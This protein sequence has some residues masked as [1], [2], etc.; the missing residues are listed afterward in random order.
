MPILTI[1]L[2]S[3]HRFRVRL[4]QTK[5]FCRQ[6]L[7]LFNSVRDPVTNLGYSCTVPETLDLTGATAGIDRPDLIFHL[8]PT[9]F[10]FRAVSY[11]GKQWSS[12]AS[13]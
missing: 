3:E 8:S 9:L 7:S 4:S 5:R 12:T 10:S 2:Y 1:Y 11:P 13:G 6:V